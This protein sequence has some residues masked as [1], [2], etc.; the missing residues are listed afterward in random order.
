MGD[1]VPGKISLF[2]PGNQTFKC[3]PFIYQSVKSF[4]WNQDV[5]ISLWVILLIVHPNVMR[6]RAAFIW[7]IILIHFNF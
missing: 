6:Q 5:F 2:E 3:I 4:D 1:I 7:S